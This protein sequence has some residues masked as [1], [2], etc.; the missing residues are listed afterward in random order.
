MQA[1]CKINIDRLLDDQVLTIKESLP[2]DFIDITET[3]EEIAK[4]I[5]DGLKNYLREG[6]VVAMIFEGYHAID[7]GRKIVGPTESRTAPVGTIRGDYSLDSYDLS[8]EQK[9]AVRNV[10]HASGDA[11]DAKK[12]IE[13]WF[14][15]K[16]IYDYHKHDWSVMF[17]KP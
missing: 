1:Q 11:D 4:G 15:K 16:D 8:S 9:R 17:N 5:H 6:P 13:L 12:E 2:L 10:I 7:I 14:D 3:D